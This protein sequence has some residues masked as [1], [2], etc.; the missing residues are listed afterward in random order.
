VVTF[1]VTRASRMGRLRK[2]V[3]V[4]G[5]RRSRAILSRKLS[6]ANVTSSLAL[7]VALSGGAYAAVALPANSVGTKQIKNGA[8]TRAKLARRSVN[9]SNVV[10]RS[11]TGA[12]IRPGSLTGANIN[13]ATLGKVQAMAGVRMAASS[14]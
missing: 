2:G 12:D 6:F 5:L 11:L 14:V 1:P 9:G 8:V 7:F 10:P 4:V 13:V 3:E